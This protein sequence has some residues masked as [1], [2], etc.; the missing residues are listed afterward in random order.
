[1]QAGNAAIRNWLATEPPH[2]YR[3]SRSTENARQLSNRP[4]QPYGPENVFL[5]VGPVGCFNAYEI[6]KVAACLLELEVAQN[7]RPGTTPL[8]EPRKDP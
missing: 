3:H 4:L 7:I 1:M 5:R 6:R 2:A 8:H